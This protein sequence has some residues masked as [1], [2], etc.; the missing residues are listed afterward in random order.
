MTRDS[1]IYIPLRD[2][3]QI[4]QNAGADL[5]ISLHA[6]SFRQSSVSGAS[7][8]TLSNTASDRKQNFLQLGRI[9]LT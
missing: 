3:V 2:R 4:A 9:S 7:V 5:F 6:D 8:Y 1:D